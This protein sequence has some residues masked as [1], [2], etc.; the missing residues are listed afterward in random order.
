MQYTCHNPDHS[1]CFHHHE[2]RK[3]HRLTPLLFS[4]PNYIALIYMLVCCYLSQLLVVRL[5]VKLKLRMF[6]SDSRGLFVFP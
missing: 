5:S 6:L 3:S 2:N 4:C 1:P